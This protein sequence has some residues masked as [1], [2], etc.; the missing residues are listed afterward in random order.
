VNE[1][2]NDA[3]TGHSGGNPVARSY[4][5]KEMVRRFG[6]PTLYAAIE[7]VCYAGLDLEKLH[8]TP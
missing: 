6:F 3:L 4:G 8:W 7:K 2:V 5:W 1:D